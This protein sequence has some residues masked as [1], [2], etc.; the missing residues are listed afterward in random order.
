MHHKYIKKKKINGKWRYYYESKNGEKKYSKV[1]SKLS[2]VIGEDEKDAFKKAES[3]YLNEMLADPD[4]LKDPHGIAE[5]LMEDW[6]ELIR[7]TALKTDVRNDEE[8]KKLLW[9]RSEG[10]KMHKLHIGYQYAKRMYESTPL[11]FA[12][13]TLNKGKDFIKQLTNH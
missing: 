1:L 12:E 13:K 7:E 4:R 11:G 6:D 10:N 8:L 9:M 5:S 2:D 3:D